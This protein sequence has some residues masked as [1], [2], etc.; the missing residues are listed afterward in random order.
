MLKIKKIKPMFTAILTTTDKYEEDVKTSGGIIDTSRTQ[1]SL[2]EFQRVVA[3]GSCVKDIKEGDLVCINPSRYAV[4]KHQEGSLKDG[5]I[6]DNPVIRYDFH[7]ITIDEVDYLLLQ[8]RDV[9]FIIEDYEEIEDT[10]SSGSFVLP[11]EKKLI[12]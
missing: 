4:K 11:E 7:V 6:T 8:D 5:V 1:G 3:V 10:S 2:K 12:I 9:D